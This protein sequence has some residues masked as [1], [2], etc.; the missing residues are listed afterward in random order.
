M[1]IFY[2]T[3]LPYY[4]RHLAFHYGDRHYLV[5][6]KFGVQHN[7]VHAANLYTIVF[8]NHIAV[9][10]LLQAV[11]AVGCICEVFKTIQ[12][13]CPWIALGGVNLVAAF[14]VINLVCTIGAA[15]NKVERAG[16]A[17]I[18]IIDSPLGAER[19]ERCVSLE[20][21]EVTPFA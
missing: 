2:L 11:V 4:M 18:G 1:L 7:E 17:C 14:P 12:A 21:L 16:N 8:L 13:I 3:Y 15:A 6:W 20:R 19:L 5:C 10:I 9:E